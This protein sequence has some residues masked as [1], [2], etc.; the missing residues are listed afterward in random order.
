VKAVHFDVIQ[1]IPRESGGLL[2]MNSHWQNMHPL[3]VI[4]PATSAPGGGPAGARPPGDEPVAAESESAAGAES[5]AESADED[6]A[7]Q[8]RL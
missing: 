3:G 1:G 8:V 6:A 2:V 5:A 7:T 4:D